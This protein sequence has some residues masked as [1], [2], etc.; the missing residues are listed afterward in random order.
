MPYELLFHF[1][2]LG[3]PQGV[4]LHTL[5]AADPPSSVF[6]AWMGV[7]HR[8]LMEHTISIKSATITVLAEGESTPRRHPTHGVPLSHAAW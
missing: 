8:Q 1:S 2:I 4:D 5:C 7:T 3:Q 6:N